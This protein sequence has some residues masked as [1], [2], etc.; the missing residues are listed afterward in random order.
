MNGVLNGVVNGVDTRLVSEAA[1]MGQHEHIVSWLS[2]TEGLAPL[3]HLDLL[4]PRRVR[5]LLRSGADIHAKAHGTGASGST[6][7]QSALAIT[8]EASASGVR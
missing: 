5:Q 1:L 3:H 4:S 7:L 8:M 2:R 6:P